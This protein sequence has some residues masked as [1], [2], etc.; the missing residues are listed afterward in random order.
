MQTK[1]STL[2]ETEQQRQTILQTAR[3]QAEALNGMY[4]NTLS[5]FL[6]APNAM[7]LPRAARAMFWLGRLRQW[8]AIDLSGDE[9]CPVPNVTSL[10]LGVIESIAGTHALALHKEKWSGP[11]SRQAYERDMALQVAM[12][13]ALE[14]RELAAFALQAWFGTNSELA[15]LHPVSGMTGLIIGVA[16]QALGVGVPQVTFQKG[17]AVLSKIVN[18]WQDSDIAFAPLA[19]ELADRHVNQCRLDTDHSLFDFDH[20]VEQ[21]IPVELLMLL[22]LR[23][24]DKV[25]AWLARH[26]AFSHPAAVM[27]KATTP[28]QSQLCHSFITSATTLLPQYGDLSAALDRQISASR[29]LSS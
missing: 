27:L 19:R 15:S 29:K 11:H 2:R 6:V 13:L 24:G 8:R 16:G 10:Q 22:R 5:A 20:P 17:D 21:A 26:G 12:L 18:H 14:W 3:A 25:P 7:P 23:D 28:S 9:A 1:S 4:Q